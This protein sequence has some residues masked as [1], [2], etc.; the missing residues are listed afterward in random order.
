MYDFE[1]AEGD[2]SARLS[3]PPVVLTALEAVRLAVELPS[4]VVLDAVIPRRDVGG[5]RPV[6][7][8]PGFYATDGLTGRV[9]GH[10]KRQ[11]YRAYSWGL[12][13]NLGLTDRIVDGLPARLDEVYERHHQP[14]SVVGWSFG[15]LLAR[16]LAH[17]RPD[18]VRQVVTLGSPWRSEGE[19]TRTTAMFEA[20]AE[21]HGLSSRA[22]EIVDTL[23]EPLPVPTT[24]I[25]SKTDGIVNWRAARSTRAPAARTSPSRAATSGS[26]RTRSRWPPSTTGS[27]RTRRARSRSSGVAPSALRPRRAPG[28]PRRVRAATS[29][30]AG[31]S[32]LALRDADYVAKVLPFLRLAMKLCF[33]SEV[34]GIERDP[35][36]GRRADRV[37]P[38]RWPD[39]DGR[40]DHRGRVR[41]PVRRRTARSTSLAHDM[42]FTGPAARTSIRGPA[43][44]RPPARTPPRC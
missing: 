34:R 38:L 12:D 16:W 5:D 14:V 18:R 21:K 24:A 7:V 19:V 31:P 15:G 37:Q 33:R 20:S 27:R 26:C 22:R 25:Y 8:L 2:P 41:R 1:G 30:I 4:S 10:L 28:R 6:L 36:R 29:P 17:E 3:R 40:A 35:R 44:C 32:R 43:S 23:R 11:G 39:A 42:L 13:R 9:R